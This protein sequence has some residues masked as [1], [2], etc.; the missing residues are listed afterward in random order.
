[1]KK[2]F[3]KKYFEKFLLVLTIFLV[4]FSYKKFLF[5][6]T[7]QEAKRMLNYFHFAKRTILDYQSFPHFSFGYCELRY[8]YEQLFTYEFFSYPEG[9]LLTPFFLIYLFLDI[10]TAE[11]ISLLLHLALGVIGIFAIGKYFG[12]S[13]GG[14]ILWAL[15]FSLSTNLLS[16]YSCGHINWK[17]IYLF[18]L[19]FYF[20]V[21]SY[22][23]KK[24]IILSGLINLLILFEGGPHI[25]IWTNLFIG[26]F[27]T[28]YFLEERKI[29]NFLNLL[30]FFLFQFLLGSIKIIPMLHFFG[31]YK[32]FEITADPRAGVGP[33]YSIKELFTA[34]TTPFWGAEYSNY[35]GIS[36]IVIF[37]LA[38]LFGLKFNRPILFTSIFFTLLT[39]NL[40]G[41]SLFHLLRK[42]P[43]FSSQRI[44]PRF[45]VMA[46]FGFGF[47]SGLLITYFKQKIKRE[48]F[49]LF[50]IFF[51]ILLSYIYFD[52]N[53]VSNLFQENCKP[54]KFREEKISFSYNPEIIPEGR[55]FLEFSFPNHRLWKLVLKK[56]SF[57]IF[58][59]LDWKKYRNVIKF[60]VFRR[61]RYENISPK[62]FNSFLSLSIPKDTRALEMRYDSPYFKAGLLISSL[63]LIFVLLICFL[64]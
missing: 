28:F 21:K 62:P 17:T 31:D 23:N 63:T 43:F 61:G 56:D 33:P 5:L 11:K 37:L 13:P 19:V 44:P 40:G 30:K 29:E 1:M 53:R 24:F 4:L 10:L 34:L 45:F 27:G 18:P 14:R 36:I 8:Y 25:F 35:I 2:I 6:C 32:P 52:L 60:R 47:L 41:F 54:L 55:I 64:I 22:K 7:P 39:V 58:K 57:A 20:W 15:I 46:I 12:M 3:Q 50:E 49:V 26:V 16:M 51:I 48:F 59:E 38:I 9:P 42:V